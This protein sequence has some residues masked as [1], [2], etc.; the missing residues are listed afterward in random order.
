MSCEKIIVTPIDGGF[1]AEIENV[2]GKSICR[3]PAREHHGVSALTH[4][5]VIIGCE[6]CG[7]LRLGFR[8]IR[9]ESAK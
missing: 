9:E 2:H 7:G 6:P 3:C 4:E 8:R 1:H 5:P